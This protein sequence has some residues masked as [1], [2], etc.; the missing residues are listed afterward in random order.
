MVKIMGIL[1][2]TPDSFWG[3][4]R[5]TADTAVEHALRMLEEGVDIIDVGAVSTRPGAAEVSPDEEWMRLE[6][7]LEALLPALPGRTYPC[8]SIDTTSSFVASRVFDVFGPFM[9]NDISAGKDDPELLGFVAEKGL[10]YVAMHKRGNSRTMDSMTDYGEEGVVNSVLRY[11]E[12][13]TSVAGRYGIKDWILDPGFGFA[14]TD[15]QNLALMDA[16]GDFKRFGRPLLVG[17]ADKR[18]THGCTEDYHRKAILSGADILRVHDV[19]AAVR[20][21]G[22]ALSG[23]LVHRDC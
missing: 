5:V 10:P 7:V 17:V 23:S 21:A 12:E 6:P 11:F 15:G 22:L 20:T 14:K 9:V 4:S 18:F 13:F 19:A 3:S 8:L 1:N 16:L 2:V